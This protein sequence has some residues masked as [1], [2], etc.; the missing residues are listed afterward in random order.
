MSES[1]SAMLARLKAMRKK[2]GL[3][4]FKNSRAQPK[5]SVHMARKRSQRSR[6]GA[7][8]NWLKGGVL[9]KRNMLIG[10]VLGVA[11]ATYVA[12]KIF[13]NNKLLQHGAAFV[14]GGVPGVVGSFAAPMVIGAV[15]GSNSAAPQG[16][17][18]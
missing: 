8:I 14:A 9:S 7:Q 18:Y 3:G 13:P 5:R 1:R 11:I 16:G 17:A 12:P 10:A 15:G 4:E 6:I 2:Y